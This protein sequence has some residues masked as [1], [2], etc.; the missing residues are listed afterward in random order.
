MQKSIQYKYKLILLL[1]W[2]PQF[3]TGQTQS[4]KVFTTLDGLVSDYVYGLAQDNMGFMWFSTPKGISRYDGRTFT[5]FTIKDGLPRNDIYDLVK[6]GNRIYYFCRSNKLGYIE[7]SRVHTFSVE[8]GTIVTPR[9]IH[10]SDN[11]FLFSNYDNWY[12][13]KNDTWRKQKVSKIEKDWWLTSYAYALKEDDDHLILVDRKTKNESILEG[14]EIVN[15]KNQRI[16]ASHYK[17]N[18]IIFV[19]TETHYFFINT[20]THSF[21]TIPND[22]GFN[23]TNF[24]QTVF[25]VIPHSTGYQVVR[26]N[27]SFFINDS[28]KILSNWKSNQFLTGNF[29]DL[30]G[31][32][33]FFE[34]GNQTRHIRNFKNNKNLLKGQNIEQVEIVDNQLYY[35]SFRKQFG[36]INLLNNEVTNIKSVKGY[37]YDIVQ[38]RNGLVKVVDNYTVSSYDPIL[39]KLEVLSKLS[40]KD[41]VFHHDKIAFATATHIELNNSE[42]I[43][44]HIGTK[45]LLSIGDNIYVGSVSG[46]YRIN[47]R[48]GDSLVCIYPNIPVLSIKRLAKNSFVFGTEENGL[49]LF[50]N[51]QTYSIPATKGLTINNITIENDSILWLSTGIGLYSI[52]LNSIHPAKSKIVSRVTTVDGLPTNLITDAA[53]YEDR[54]YI[55]TNEGITVI[56]KVIPSSKPVLYL[57]QLSVNGKAYT[58]DKEI[59]L[60][61]NQNNINIVFGAI[62][63]RGQELMVFRFKVLPEDMEWTSIRNPEIYLS[64][65]K[66]GNYEVVLNIK[67]SHEQT[68]QKSIF[69]KISEPWWNSPVF[70]LF[71]LVFIV[72]S[73]FLLFMRYKKI[74][75]AKT[76]KQIDG[77]RRMDEQKMKALRSQINPH[78][79]FNSLNAIQYL[80]SK[81][82]NSSAEQYL[83]QF[84][85]L[86]R[87]FLE[88][89]RKES[90]TIEEEIRALGSYLSIEKM[91]FEGKLNYQISAPNID[92][93]LIRI[94]TLVLQPI[95][96]NAVNHGIFHKKTDG[97]IWISMEE[98]KSGGLEVMII[99]DGIGVKNATSI[100]Q[101]KKS[102]F[103]KILNERI[104]LLN[105]SDIWRI[106]MET[107]NWRND[108]EN[109]GT[110]VSIKFEYI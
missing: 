90:V 43:I 54:L 14:S 66:P 74:Q 20:K 80:I 7:N 105:N 83:I 94:P 107:K 5:S 79:V 76:K 91:R 16:L 65:L 12:T 22:I 68:S 87:V 64:N 51:D 58:L 96:E 52:I 48:T 77:I 55:S 45:K 104:E 99:D 59:K 42:T 29:T 3:L 106:N 30:W 70:K 46:L 35:G 40:A 56:P 93:N 95:V 4:T 84:S 108:T 62:D 53:I 13:I 71:L 49:Y 1:F 73:L 82:R 60:A 81:K 92:T 75:A 33:W 86:V 28:L 38:M 25:K 21:K 67:N 34:I 26:E 50:R 88:M 32:Q 78:F 23:K 89:S 57:E 10:Y 101:N 47:L 100:H 72:A 69:F 102:L 44:N 15:L 103:G 27:Y 63:S 24:H 110:L 36:K 11:K 97:N 9:H 109:P 37:I 31:D 85:K 2:L 98:T 18:N 6:A 17:L 61:H 19:L 39:K 8:D 41:L